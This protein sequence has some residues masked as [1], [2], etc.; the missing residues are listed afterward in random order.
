MTTTKEAAMFR[1]DEILDIIGIPVAWLLETHT[2]C[3]FCNRKKYRYTNK[4]DNGDW[5]CS[6]GNGNGFALV[7]RHLNCDFKTA[8][9]KVDEI[10]GRKGDANIASEKEKERREL[11][12]R[13]TKIWSTAQKRSVLSDYL[14]YR[15]LNSIPEG[16]RGHNGLRWQ[17]KEESG[18]DRAMVA[19]V[20]KVD[21]TPIAIHRTFILAEG[22]KVR[23]MSPTM[24][25][26]QGS[27]I[28]LYPA[29]DELGIAEGIE[30][31]IA[32]HELFDMPVWSCVS[33]SLMESVKIPDGVKKVIIFADND[34]NY[35]GQ[36][37][38]Y[39]LANRLVLREKLEVDVMIPTYE[40]D[41][42]DEYLR[43][44]G[45]R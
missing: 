13:L 18:I 43:K 24:E 4:T 30:T 20:K 42:L 16:L 15:G 14:L 34:K 6:C 29:G 23:M 39:K 2:E 7:Q 26:L 9:K 5:I 22:R 44:Q 40:G 19:Q 37:S 35:T 28:Q 11:R 32:C 17:S 10:I 33:A 45:E 3:P 38:A 12:D 8:A 36:A 25:P 1:W 31:A 27:A 21:G 41:W